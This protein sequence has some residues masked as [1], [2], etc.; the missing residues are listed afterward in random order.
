[1]TGPWLGRWWPGAG[2]VNL[3][4]VDGYYYR[5]TDTFNSVFETTLEQIRSFAKTPVIISEVG[6][7][8]NPSRDGQIR[9]LFA[10][11]EASHISAVI[12]FDA[13]QHDGIYHQDWQL[14]GHPSALVAFRAAA[15]S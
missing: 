15:A 3:V 1:V 11:V 6:I 9:A 5:A 13:P 8:P 10:G 7:G 12:W 14:E 4:G 2:W